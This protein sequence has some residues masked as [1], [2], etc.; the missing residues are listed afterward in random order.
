M[1][2]NIIIGPPEKQDVDCII[3]AIFNNNE[4]SHFTKYLDNISNNYIS[5]ILKNSNKNKN[6]DS[7]ILYDIPNINSN[8]IILIN[9]GNKNNCSKLEYKKIIYNSLTIIEKT[10]SNKALFLINND[11]N[12]KNQ[13]IFYNTKNLIININNF[14]YNFN[15][16]KTNKKNNYLKNIIIYSTKH[17]LNNIQKSIKYGIIISKSIKY[18]KDLSNSPPSICT[19]SYLSNEAY[20]LSKIYKNL[21]VKIINKKEI[22]KLKMNLIL[23]VSKGSKENPKLIIL[24]Y[25]NNINQKPI[26]L[27]GKGITFDSGGICLKSTKALLGMKYDM[28]GVSSIYGVFIFILEL[29]IKINIIGIIPATENMIDGKS[30]KTNDIIK[31]MSGQ[32]IE[33]LNTDAEGRLVLCDAITYSKK[34]NPFIIIDIATLTGATIIALGKNYTAL[35]SNNSKLAND[36]FIA[37]KMI[38]D[39]CWKMPLSKIYNEKLKNTL[40]DISNIG[41]ETGSINAACF[42]SNFTKN[43][44]WAHL[45]IAGTAT[46]INKTEEAT[47]RPT[48]L[49]IQ[50]IIN[51]SSS[52]K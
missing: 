38:D 1:K 7:L 10:N 5:N 17:E 34:Y 33:I 37:G 9:C 31:S 39:F 16:Y 46:T 22:K 48:K 43:I 6:L 23:S 13:N 29:K 20:N 50:Y 2:I 30:I 28:C 25:N 14:N 11:C 21:S 41:D 47:G 24:K 36:L 35:Y 44:P 8:K 3:T 52:I 18:A 32:T 45:D 15:K 12:I 27:I 49:L 4:L 26:V 40:A 42:L 19:P 51:L